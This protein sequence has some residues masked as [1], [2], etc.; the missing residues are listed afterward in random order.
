MRSKLKAPPRRK[1]V[2]E[3]TSP[4]WARKTTWA[5]VLARG[6]SATT[7]A[8]IWLPLLSPKKAAAL[9]AAAATVVAIATILARQG[10]VNAAARGLEKA[11]EEREGDDGE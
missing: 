7:I 4:W 9:S 1:T 5:A 8:N 10:G 2:H 3:L 6:L 11:R